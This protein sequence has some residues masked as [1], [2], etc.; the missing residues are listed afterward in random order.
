MDLALKSIKNSPGLYLKQ[1]SIWRGLLFKD[2]TK[3]TVS[4]FFLLGTG[5]NSDSDL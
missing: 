3:T 5:Q 1:V 2:V 4:N